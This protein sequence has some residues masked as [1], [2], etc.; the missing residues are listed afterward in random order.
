MRTHTVSISPH[1]IG[2]IGEN[3]EASGIYQLLIALNGGKRA[4]DRLWFFERPFKHIRI[5]RSETHCYRT[6]DGRWYPCSSVG[7]KTI[8]VHYEDEQIMEEKYQSLKLNI[9]S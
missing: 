4:N 9:S 6:E 1:A 8:S 3:D 7:K 5:P 2:I